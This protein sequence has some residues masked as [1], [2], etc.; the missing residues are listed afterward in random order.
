M[1]SVDR[2]TG[3]QVGA[4]EAPLL[5]Q[6]AHGHVVARDEVAHDL[7]QVGHVVFGLQALLVARKA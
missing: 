1:S 4:E 6:V 5:F 7:E 2:L 3:L